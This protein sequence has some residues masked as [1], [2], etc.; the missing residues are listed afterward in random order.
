MNMTLLAGTDLDVSELCLGTNPFG[1]TASEQ[2]AFGVL[3]AYVAAG[4]NF[5]DTADVYSRWAEGNSGG[6]AETVIGHWIARRGRSDDMVIATKVGS[7][8]GLSA[9]NVRKCVDDS[10]RRLQ[11]ERIDLYYAH[12]DHP[13]TPLE[14]TLGVFDEL[15]RS[16]K[17]RY[18]G[19][20][21]Y[22]PERLSEA[23]AIVEREGY[24]PLVAQTPHYNLL[25]RSYETGLA[26]ILT[27]HGMS[28]IPYYGLAKGFLTGKYRAGEENPSNRGRLDGSGYVNE[29]GLR[30]LSAVERIATDRATTTAAV[31][32]AWLSAQPTVVAPIA[33]ARTTDQMADLLPMTDLRL[34][35][36]ELEQLDVVSADAPAAH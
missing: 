20:S 16:G 22:E 9:S 12:H 31:A 2:D 6:E 18:L 13:E 21:N 25:E 33:S 24:A 34:T 4:G 29:R 14:E 1:W 36:F 32:L 17:V 11:I 19:V 28:C 10:L 5:L 23:L 27:E 7:M 26:P 8:G 15:V 3:D 35:Y 30:V